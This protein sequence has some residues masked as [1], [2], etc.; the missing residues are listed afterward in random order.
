[1]DF[2]HSKLWTGI[3]LLSRLYPCNPEILASA[4]NHVDNT[5]A[6]IRQAAVDAMGLLLNYTRQAAAATTTAA[7]ASPNSHRGSSGP[8]REFHTLWIQISL[9]LG[10]QCEDV[11]AAAATALGC[12]YDPAPELLLP[13]VCNNVRLHT[14][15][16]WPSSCLRWRTREREDEISLFIFF[17]SVWFYR[18]LHLGRSGPRR[19][20]CQP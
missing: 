19:G 6:Q 17:F 18:T 16:M 13:L 1:M 14:K 12:C 2:Y 8:A 10:D 11:V 3:V 7:A 5:S 20:A 15:G 4:W 9:C